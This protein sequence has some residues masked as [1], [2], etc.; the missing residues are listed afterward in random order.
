LQ[1]IYELDSKPCHAKD[2]YSAMKMYF[3]RGEEP[4]FGDELNQWLWPR[5]FGNIWNDGDPEVFLG[6]GSILYNYDYLP[7]GQKKIVFCA[8]Y[9][10]YSEKPDMHDGSWDVYFV[11]GPQTAEVLG[12]D[13]KSALTD[14]AVLVRTATLPPPATPVITSFMPHFQSIK[15]GNWQ[16][17]CDQAGIRFIDP[18]SAVDKVLSQILGS[19][20]LLTEAMH[21]AIV[22][23]AL[24]IP[25]VPLLPISTSHH[26][27]WAD[28]MR[29]IEMEF[30]PIRL[31]PSSSREAWMLKTGRKAESKAARAVAASAIGR[32]ADAA[33]V[34]LAVQNL[35]NAANGRTW[36]SEERVI[37]RLTDRA[38]EMT[39]KFKRDFGF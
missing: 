39:D 38:V 22:A 9:G 21:G 1:L 2:K 13:P 7:R 28:W 34:P 27:K 17:V 15:R 8:G 12:L 32:M 19:Q 16:E 30:H 14:A 31:L 25:W 4:N 18:R 20:I 23:D 35:V 29:S 11:R 26:F 3:F 24:R 6:I 37:A 10:G 33:L 36:L 5:V